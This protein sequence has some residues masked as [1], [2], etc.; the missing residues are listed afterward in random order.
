[1]TIGRVLADPPRV[2]SLDQRELSAGEVGAKAAN[3]ARARAA[4]LPVVSGFVIPP[5]VA[6]KLAATPSGDRTPEVETVRTAWGTL[7]RGGSAAVVVRSSSVAEDTAS[8][9]HAGVFDSVVDVR[10]WDDFLD[11]VRTVAVSA[12]RAANVVASAPLAVLVQRHLD[13]VRSGVLFTIDPVSGRSDQMV[14]AVVDGGPQQLV[15]GAESGTRVVLKRRTRAVG[16]ARGPLPRRQCM[17]LVRLGLRAE[18]LFGGPQDIEWALGDDGRPV[19]LQSRPIT[20]HGA[21]VEQ[22]PV[23]GPG[24]VAETFPDPLHPLEQDLWLTPLREAIRVVL[25]LTGAATRRT[26]ERSALVITIDGR[27]AV[28]LDL[29]EGARERRR[30]LG[31][32]DPRPPARRLRVA[33]QVG[34]LRRGLPDLISD[35]LADLDAELATV[36]ALNELTDEELLR[37]LERGRAALQAAQGYELLAGVLTDDA[38]TSGAALALRALAEGRAAGLTDAEIVAARPAVLSL[39]APAITRSVV[40]PA[41]RTDPACGAAHGVPGSADPTSLGQREALRLRIRWLQEV[42]GLA[43]WTLGARL[44]LEGVIVQPADVVAFDLAR[45]TQAVR[46]RVPVEPATRFLIARSTPLPNRFRLAGDGSV[47]AVEDGRARDGSAAGGGRG[48]GIVEHGEAPS[49]GAVLVVDTLDPRLASVLADLGGL[50]AATG[51]PLSHLAIL[52]REHGVPTVVGVTD[53]TRRF[54]PGTE[55]LV[56]GTSGEV[57]VLHPAVEAGS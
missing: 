7:S 31:L 40:L 29:L 37:L 56:D 11:A 42:T 21:A 32:L 57:R 13:P 15:S 35:L 24:P 22:G 2:V 46:E 4:G 34:R 12:S 50:V 5:A 44:V 19:L 33:W 20:A 25:Q 16:R 53:A 49:A 52:A 51:S 30:G 48:V 47:V 41:S 1:M 55:L 8:S 54:P 43:A 38:Q 23:Y 17:A 26:L 14:V 6:A 10:G 36:P 45:L 18:A 9:S 28:D 39:T 27:A 3:L